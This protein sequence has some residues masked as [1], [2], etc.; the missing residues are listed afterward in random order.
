MNAVRRAVAVLALL[1]AGGCGGASTA[2]VAAPGVP[3]G[4]PCGTVTI[5]VNPW[6]G[7]AANVAVVGY[8]LRTELGCTVRTKEL[9]EDDSWAG[10]ASGE[11]DVILENW[12]HDDL[13]R[14]YID[15]QK[16][17]VS[18]GATG[19]QGVIGWYVPPWMKAEHPDITDWQTLN[20]YAPLFRTGRSGKRGQFLAGDPSFVTNDAAL[21]TNL[22]LNY[23]VVHAGSEDRLIRAFQRAEADRTP[24]LGYFYEP[25]WLLAELDLVHIPLPRHRPG[26]DVDPKAVACDYPAYLLDKVG[27]AGFLRSGSPAVELIENF[28]WTNADQNAVARDLTVNGLSPDE[29]ARRWLTA[30]PRQW[31]KWLP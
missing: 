23:T 5:A 18:L 3:A 9:T 22:R 11:V 16:V 24:L 14:R 2:I 10:I 20:R 19:N 1:L 7:Y 30:H 26:C 12:G 31:R 25:Q 8:L 27:R 6:A 21:I 15:Q 13:R 4:V 17:A 28:R 29:A